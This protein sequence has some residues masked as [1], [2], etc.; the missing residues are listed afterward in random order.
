M[1][2]PARPAGAEA[3]CMHLDVEALE[4]TLALV[5]PRGEEL[6]D[7]FYARLF[8]AAPSIKP[9]FANADLARHEAMLPSTLVLLR[10]SMRDLDAIAPT[11]RALGA[12]H[13]A[14]AA[15]PQHYVAVGQ[16]LIDSLAEIAGDAWRPEH[17]LAWAA[18]LAVVADVMLSGAREAEVALA[19]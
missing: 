12:R 19:A 8:A 10:R 4:T 18:A 11:L 1:P 7:A 16:A 6:M 9:L 5:A 14:Y 2:L 13:A 15:E 3:V 17:H